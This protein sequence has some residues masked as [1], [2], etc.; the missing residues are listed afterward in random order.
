MSPMT[1]P[2]MLRRSAE[3]L[4]QST[5]QTWALMAVEHTLREVQEA[6]YKLRPGLEID[7]MLGTD[8]PVNLENTDG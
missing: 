5:D 8:T 6:L 2:Q 3:L 1:L 4:E 7:R